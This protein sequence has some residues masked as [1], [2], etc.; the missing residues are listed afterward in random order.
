MMREII[1]LAGVALAASAAGALAWRHYYPRSFWLVAV[2]PLRTAHLYLTWA[3]VAAGCGLS[4]TRRRWRWT[5]EAVP[6]AGP[7]AY[8]ARGT[9]MATQRRRIRRVSVEHAPPLGIPWPGA[10][11]WRVKVGGSASQVLVP[12][13]GVVLV[14]RSPGDRRRGHGRGRPDKRPDVARLVAGLGRR[15][16]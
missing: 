15:R 2:F 5:L 6:V 3:H 14:T 12:P 8:A 10:L 16:A 1:I 4:T 13:G 9:I 7:L 11:G